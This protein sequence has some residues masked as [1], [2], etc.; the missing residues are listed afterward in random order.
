MQPT[1][2]AVGAKVE[3]DAAPKGR[4]RSYDIDSGGT[5]E[6]LTETR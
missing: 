5:T 1:A 6:I 4:K 3:Y 2:R